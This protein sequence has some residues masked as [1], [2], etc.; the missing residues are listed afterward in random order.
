MLCTILAASGF[1]GA[2]SASGALFAGLLHPAR[3]ARL[4][5]DD[6]AHILALECGEYL[7]LLETVDDLQLLAP[8]RAGQVVEQHALDDD[9]G[10]VA[11]GKLLGLD[12]RDVRRR[13]ILL[14]IVGVEAVL[15]LDVDGAA[16]AE[17]LAGEEHARIGAVRR[18]ARA[19]L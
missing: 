5:R 11:L 12:P 9:V 6:R 8:A 3:S 16:R 13:R 7:T 18:D 10:Q 17:E 1:R 15:V 4:S 2:G 19:L 14:R